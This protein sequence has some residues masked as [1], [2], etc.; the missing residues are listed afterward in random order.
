MPPQLE[1]F[2]ERRD[3][4]LRQA[5]RGGIDRAGWLHIAR[6]WQKLHD[7][8]SPR[9]ERSPKPT[10]EDHETRITRK[11]QKWNLSARFLNPRR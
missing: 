3:Q 4:A 7:A 11:F 10:R 5:E 9:L 8:L 1:Y 6:E 2:V